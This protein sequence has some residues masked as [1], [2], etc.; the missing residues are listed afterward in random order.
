MQNNARTKGAR[1]ARNNQLDVRIG[2]N[3][4]TL[5]LH[6][7]LTLNAQ[8]IE[9]L[10]ASLAFVRASMQ[11]QVQRDPPPFSAGR[12]VINPRHAVLADPLGESIFTFIR[13]PMF[14]WISLAQ[15]Q[16]EAMQMVLALA[17]QLK[18]LEMEK[19]VDWS[20]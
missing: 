11:P 1:D 18:L 5:T 9:N 16:D 17:G 8:Q 20:H 2:R 3:T 12:F 4:A 19:S 15:S 10:V 14:G 13:H 7:S 6:G